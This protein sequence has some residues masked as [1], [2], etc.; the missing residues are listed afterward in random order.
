MKFGLFVYATD[1]GCPIADIGV[2]GEKYRLESL[3]VCEHSHVPAPPTPYVDPDGRVLP[4]YYSHLFDPLIALAA[5]AGSTTNI[6]LGTATCIA[7]QRDP[8]TTAKAIA[9]LDQVSR[10][11]LEFGVGTGWNQDESRA[12]G[13][14]P[15]TVFRTLR[16]KVLLMRELWTSDSVDL[17]FLEDVGPIAQWPHPYRH[18]HPPV[19][20]AGNGPR[21]LERVE[22][23]G[24]GW[25]PTYKHPNLADASRSLR[26]LR[27]RTGKPY[28]A[29]IIAG[30]DDLKEIDEYASFGIDRVLLAV[31]PGTREETEDRV[32][33]IADLSRRANGPVLA[34]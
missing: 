29:T 17:P 30:S 24:D 31:R 7:A 26:D 8:I 34:T 18:P 16:E 13:V 9:T 32:A 23:Y 6:V 27:D 12:H 20:V 15:G 4:K 10:G 3:F 5:L 33:A 19:L 2:L 21:I 1:L 11:R 14:D 25:L 22:E 28:P